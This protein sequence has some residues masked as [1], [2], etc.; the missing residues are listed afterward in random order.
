MVLFVQV[1]ARLS[2]T[3]QILQHLY[4]ILC[5]PKL[6]PLLNK[7]SFLR[8]QSSVLQCNFIVQV[9]K[10]PAWK[11]GDQLKPLIWVSLRLD[12]LHQCLREIEGK[13]DY[14]GE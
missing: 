12:V 9:G 1:E 7:D 8:A 10:L 6:I 14:T 3:N 5:T 13:R 2:P 11:V 4:K